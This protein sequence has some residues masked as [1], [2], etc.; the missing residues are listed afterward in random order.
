M[1]G[2]D[3]HEA[4]LVAAA[5]SAGS[6]PAAP[7]PIARA[8]PQ[9]PPT[10]LPVLLVNDVPLKDLAGRLIRAA[11]FKFQELLKTLPSA[12]GPDRQ[13][14]LLQYAQSQRE[15]FEKLLVLTRFGR[16]AK[17]WQ[18][19]MNVHGL[20]DRRTECMARAGHDLRTMVAQLRARIETSA[21]DVLGALD[22]LSNKTYTQLP[23]ILKD[24]LPAKPPARSETKAIL[25]E[26]DKLIRRR[27]ELEIIPDAM[28]ANMVIGTVSAR[29]RYVVN[30]FQLALTL[31][32]HD[33]SL[34]WRIVELEFFVQS[35]E[36]YKGLFS[37]LL[38]H[39][40]FAILQQAQVLVEQVQKRD[41]RGP[42]F[43]ERAT[44]NAEQ[45]APASPVAITPSKKDLPA[46]SHGEAKRQTLSDGAATETGPGPTR[47]KPKRRK[48]GVLSASDG[49]E[50]K[51]P[52]NGK[53][54][55]PVTAKEKGKKKGL[56]KE[57]V[58]V[59]T[60]GPAPPVDVTVATASH[61]PETSA[62][63]PPPPPKPEPPKLH[64]PYPILYLY[65]YLHKLLLRVQLEILTAQAHS[66]ARDRWH[67]L[68]K[69]E[70]FREIETV[71]LTYWSHPI[72]RPDPRTVPAGFKVPN[73][74]CVMELA[75]KTDPP[76]KNRAFDRWADRRSKGRGYLKHL[77]KDLV[78]ANLFG[79]AV[80]PRTRFDI[81]CYSVVPDLAGG[82]TIEPLVNP[83]TGA[84]IALALNPSR[85]DLGALLTN[86]TD[87]QAR[88][89]LH[90][91]QNLLV[92][93]EPSRGLSAVH[94]LSR[95]TGAPA[96]GVADPPRQAT[97]K[98]DGQIPVPPKPASTPVPSEAVPL[99]E[100]A[101]G[102][103]SQSFR[104]RDVQLH[105]WA[106]SGDS[107][108]A[109]Q[110]ELAVSLHKDVSASAKV[111]TWTG[112]VLLTPPGG[113]IRGSGFVQTPLESVLEQRLNDHPGDA[114]EIFLYM[115]YSS[116]ME[117]I[118]TWCEQLGLKASIVSPLK[119]GEEIRA[120]GF[121][122]QNKIFVR[123]AG[124]KEAWIL[125]AVAGSEDWEAAAGSLGRAGA[126]SLATTSAAH[127]GAAEFRIWL[128]ETTFEGQSVRRFGRARREMNREIVRAT[129][130]RA[131]D[132][133]ALDAAGR[134]RDARKVDDLMPW[135]PPEPAAGWDHLDTYTLAA[136]ERM[137]R[138]QH[139]HNRVAAALEALRIQYCYLSPD[140]NSALYADEVQPAD[141]ARLSGTEPRICVPEEE[142]AVA[143]GKLA[144]ANNQDDRDGSVRTAQLPFGNLYVSVERHQLP[145][146]DTGDGSFAS[147]DLGVGR[148]TEVQGIR[149]QGICP[150]KL[151]IAHGLLVQHD[152]ATDRWIYKSAMEAVTFIFDGEGLLDRCSNIMIDELVAI[153][154]IAELAQQ[155]ASHRTRLSKIGV[156]VDPFDLQSLYLTYNHTLRVRV[157][158]VATGQVLA[159]G[160]GKN[161]PQHSYCAEMTC[162]EP[163]ASV[164]QPA[165]GKPERHQIPPEMVARIQSF[166]VQNLN[167][168]R[169]L[170]RAFL[171]LWHLAPLLRL[172]NELERKRNTAVVGGENIFVTV[173][174]HSLTHVQLVYG[175]Q[176]GVELAMLPTGHFA[177]Y[178]ST[179]L[180]G[181]QRVG[182]GVAG[183]GLPGNLHARPQ[184]SDPAAGLGPIPLFNGLIKGIGRAAMGPEFPV[185]TSAMPVSFGVSFHPAMLDYVVT[186]MDTHLNNVSLLL[187]IES[188]AGKRL[189]I[190]QNSHKNTHVDLPN[191]RA[192]IN[193]DAR[194][195]MLKVSAT[196]SWEVGL[197]PRAP[198]NAVTDELLNILADL[199]AEK[200]NNLPSG[201]DL[202]PFLLFFLDF[203]TM[204]TKV[205]TNLLCIA[206]DERRFANVPEEGVVAEWC[207]A[208]PPE[209]PAYIGPPNAPGTEFDPTLNRISIIFR[210]TN[211]QTSRSLLV[212]LRY[213]YQTDVIGRWQANNADDFTGVQEMNPFML[214]TMQRAYLSD[215]FTGL[216][217]KVM[218]NYTDEILRI[219]KLATLI[220]I[221]VK[222]C[223][224]AP[225]GLDWVLG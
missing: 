185:G 214:E 103:S 98:W 171:V 37:G 81:R 34:P 117:R 190:P 48:T 67:K 225:A 191:M 180:P 174:F 69:V 136:I 162:I 70:E 18:Q 182:G 158:A 179:L 195:V 202:R 59:A 75:I 116:F 47:M 114:P 145:G 66:L 155:V 50:G 123:V 129:P 132:V 160:V 1:E 9:A 193:T 25:H 172:V 197:A 181:R 209:A 112:R 91:L 44:A 99:A 201:T 221:A 205:V 68:L 65:E 39:Q 63:D 97:F 49:L 90:R 52:I 153:G 133:F 14:Q 8:A 38:G 36:S 148:P 71:R 183:G 194:S 122:I 42:G 138:L 79:D 157:W 216:M 51:K 210:V 131:R 46:P 78:A 224:T 85:L 102:S 86:V 130:I 82:R 53:V 177:F 72:P 16:K 218:M 5:D 73:R 206:R 165:S 176:H 159:D 154:A 164:G 124:F 128:V 184:P 101:A 3:D 161:G 219:S 156:A 173:K 109:M 113:A 43:T 7:E 27:I 211:L 83:E 196:N 93:A 198:E 26:L 119:N 95:V 111:D 80:R 74:H 169:D 163:R 100:D 215:T 6:V 17:D 15:D 143:M 223:K 45:S 168:T 87:L 126:P 200:I 108:E 60:D 13:R 147:A 77:S 2:G 199:V 30:R 207:F 41:P 12:A 137:C 54:P 208:I 33:F 62:P 150:V 187:W 105:E 106:P 56:K 32:G 58:T 167:E 189:P 222:R 96:E 140:G 94:L 107:T 217:A 4:Q 152:V 141:R 88:F 192:T 118:S 55:K 212:P 203:L 20:I 166:W 24:A 175:A 61:T 127:A 110:C 57:K 220:R 104:A 11:D 22:I 84:P 170:S 28:R 149:V 64:N 144:L 213:N 146:H 40:K 135:R 134:Y 151:G 125:I 21:P 31:V 139:A 10:P 35:A 115:R 142:L 89:V 120:T 19:V 29:D 178:D 186:K 121:P 76:A 23:R 92:G 188:E 204:P